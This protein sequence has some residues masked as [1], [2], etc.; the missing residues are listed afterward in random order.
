MSPVWP[1]HVARRCWRPSRRQ[2]G[3]SCRA[4]GHRPV[5]LSGR[6]GRRGR[7]NNFSTRRHAQPAGRR[8]LSAVAST[9]GQ[10]LRCRRGRRRRGTPMNRKNLSS[11]PDR[12]LMATVDARPGHAGNPSAGRLRGGLHGCSESACH[13]DPPT[14]EADRARGP[15]GSPEHR[16]ETVTV[17]LAKLHDPSGFRPDVT[18]DQ[19]IHVHIDLGRVFEA[20]ETIDAALAEYQQALEACEH[21]GLGRFRSSRPGAGGT[22]DRRG[23]RPIGPLRPVRGPLQE[24]D[25]AQPQR[26]QGLERRRIQL[27]SP[28]TM[29]RCRAV[30][31]D[32]PANLSGR[33]PDHDEPRA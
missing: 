9:G 17:D 15:G 5:A 14:G 12:S 24:G 11:Q 29:G 13:A 22:P 1:R 10:R 26:P 16:P 25:P 19:R 4:G 8:D 18:R 2:D 6:H 33:C 30:L 3:P 21:K 27:L 31:Q 32:R 20:R 7:R 23:A 28:G